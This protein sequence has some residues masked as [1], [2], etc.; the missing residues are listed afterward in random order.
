MNTE[1]SQ[2]AQN[3]YFNLVVEG[4]GCLERIRWVKPERKKDKESLWCKVSALCGEKGSVEYR[5]YD[6]KVVGAEAIKLVL[7]CQNKANAKNDDGNSKHKVLVG[8]RIGDP[9][10]EI[11]YKGG[12][13]TAENARIMVKGR[14]LHLDWIKV[15]GQ[16][17]HSAGA[18]MAETGA[19][20]A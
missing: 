4:V 18:A 5:P 20:A 3:S 9:S 1:S 14:L 2:Q 17:V 15:D 7:R 19:A 13:K 10:P 8:F 12:V 11:Y 16:T 6:C